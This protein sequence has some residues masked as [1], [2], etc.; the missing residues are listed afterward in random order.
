MISKFRIRF[1]IRALLAMMAIVAFTI[2]GVQDW[3]RLQVAREKYQYVLDSLNMMYVSL[4][5]VAKSSETLMHAEAGSIWI[6][7]NGAER[8]HVDR[9]KLLAQRA[10]SW[11]KT[12]L[13][14]SDGGASWERA[15]DDIRAE[16]DQ[17]ASSDK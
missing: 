10:E 6:T 3:R 5:D 8:R 14:G 9:L 11:K 15:I 2:Y 4:K 12:M 7:N 1:S 16:I 13:F 17:L